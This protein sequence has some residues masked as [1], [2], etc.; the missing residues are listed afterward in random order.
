M[1]FGKDTFS[2][3]GGAVDSLFSGLALQTKAKGSRIE[4]ENYDL[5]ANLSLENERYTR[6]STEIKQLQTDRDI[7]R[8][9]GETRADIAGS[10]LSMSG[11]A[12]DILKDSASQGAL[13]KAVMG[14]QGY[15]EE[16]SY[17]Q[18]ADSF[19]LMASA[20]RMAAAADDTAAV[21]SFIS[22]GIKAASGL[23]TL[24]FVAKLFT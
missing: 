12:L 3:A 9:Q 14:E 21:G 7:Y 11:S 10:G 15:L 8:S 6:H 16:A 20:S 22:S 2:L 24:D 18:Q 19:K 13:T 1:A 4:A 23:G 5:S 17:Q